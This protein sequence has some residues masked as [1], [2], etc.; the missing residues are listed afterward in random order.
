MKTRIIRLLF[1]MLLVLTLSGCDLFG[2]ISSISTD[3]P[4][5]T[6][7]TTTT[8][9]TTSNSDTGLSSSTTIVQGVT[10]TFIEN[11]GIE[12]NDI[13]FPYGTVIAQPQTTRVGYQLVGWY[14]DANLTLPFNF[15]NPITA[16][17][18]LYAKWSV[19]QVPVNLIFADGTTLALQVNYGTTVADIIASLDT[20]IMSYVGGIFSDLEFT[21]SISYSTVVTD[22]L[23]FYIQTPEF[24]TITYHQI[25]ELSIAEYYSDFVFTT[26]GHLYSYDLAGLSMFDNYYNYTGSQQQETVYYDLNY[27][28]ELNL[29]EVI[30]RVIDVNE[31]HVIVVTNQDRALLFGLNESNLLANAVMPNELYG[32]VDLTSVLSL[33]TGEQITSAV[34]T[35]QSILVSTSEER[36][37][38]W[39]DFAV[40]GVNYQYPTPFNVTNEFNLLEGETFKHDYVN[41]YADFGVY[42]LTNSRAFVLQSSFAPFIPGMVDDGAIFFDVSTLLETPE[43]I[44]FFYMEPHSGYFLVTES[45]RVRSYFNDTDYDL[46]YDLA[47]NETIVSFTE[48]GL[49]LTSF[50]NVYLL[51]NVDDIQ[52][53]PQDWLPEGEKAV[54]IYDS[55]EYFTVESNANK[56]YVMSGSELYDISSI[57][58]DYDLS[59]D[60]LTQCGRRTLLIKDGVYYEVYPRFLEKHNFFGFVPTTI[61][62]TDLSSVTA[63][64]IQNPGFILSDWQDME[65]FYVD[66][67]TLPP[68][69]YDL[70]PTRGEVIMFPIT[71]SFEN[72][73]ITI[74]VIKDSTLNAET[75][76][77]YIPYRY[78]LDYFTYNES[79]IGDSLVI[80]DA[81]EDQTIRVVLK[82]AET[83]TIQFIYVDQSEEILGT[84][85]NVV[86]SGDVATYYYNPEENID[87]NQYIEGY[88]LD[89]E[90]TMPYDI[91]ADVTSDL[92]IYIQVLDRIVYTISF[93]LNDTVILDY[94]IAQFDNLYLYW[95][96]VMEPVIEAAQLNDNE[97]IDSFYLNSE[98]TN[99]VNVIIG[100][101]NYTV[102]VKIGTI[103]DVTLMFYD[104]EGNYLEEVITPFKDTKRVEEQI[105][106]YLNQS[107]YGVELTSISETSDFATTVPYDRYFDG[108]VLTYHIKLTMLPLVTVHLHIRPYDAVTYTVYDIEIVS[109]CNIEE[110]FEVFK[111]NLF[112]DSNLYTDSGLTTSFNGGQILEDID[113]YAIGFVQKEITVTYVFQSGL[114]TYSSTEWTPTS[115][116]HYSIISYIE[117]QEGYQVITFNVFLD[118]NYETEFSGLLMDDITLYITYEINEPYTLTLVSP[119]GLFTDMSRS[120]EYPVYFNTQSLYYDF[121]DFIVSGYYHF[122]FNYYTNVEMTDL[123]IEKEISSDTT[124]YV[125]VIPDDFITVTVI[126]DTQTNLYQNFLLKTNTMFYDTPV[127]QY[128]QDILG[129]YENSNFRLY[130]DSDHTQPYYNNIEILTGTT[131]Y[132]EAVP[133]EMIT[134][135]FE[136]PGTDV[137][138]FDVSRYNGVPIDNSIVMG[139]LQSNGYFI[140]SLDV[141]LY[142]D[143]TMTL[144]INDVYINQN[145]FTVYVTIDY[146]EPELVTFTFIGYNLPD[147][148][149]EIYPY[150]GISDQFYQDIDNEMSG[151]SYYFEIFIDNELTKSYNQ[152]SSQRGSTLYV[153]LGYYSNIEHTITLTSPEFGSYEMIATEG[154]A[155][156][157]SWVIDYYYSMIDWPY[158]VTISGIYSDE[159]MT[160][161]VTYVSGNFDQT[162][163]VDAH[164]LQTF[165]LTLNL[166]GLGVYTMPIIEQDYLLRNTISYYLWNGC[167]LST[168]Y[169]FAYYTNP[170]M[171]EPY[172]DIDRISSDIMLY[173]NVMERI[174]SYVNYYLEDGTYLASAQYDMFTSLSFFRNIG[175]DIRGRFFGYYMGQ[176]STQPDF[177][178]SLDHE[179]LFDG[180]VTTY[181]VKIIEYEL[182]PVELNLIHPVTNVVETITIMVHSSYY[183]YEEIQRLDSIVLSSDIYLD[184]TLF[185]NF[186]DRIYEPVE[187]Y[188]QGYVRQE[189]TLTL[190]FKSGINS[191]IFTQF[192]D[193]SIP[194]ESLRSYI[195]NYD[196]GEITQLRF[197]TD[198]SYSIAFNGVIVSD[199]TLYVDYQLLE[200]YTLTLVSTDGLFADQSITLGYSQWLESFYIYDFFMSNFL[201]GFNASQFEF[202]YDVEMTSEF[203]AQEYN[204]SMTIY[205]KANLDAFF[206]VTVLFE[207]A[208]IQ[209]KVFIVADG[210]EFYGYYIEY[211]LSYNFGE[212]PNTI[213]RYYADA[214]H[215][216][217]YYFT[218]I[219][220][221]TT[222]Y[223]YAE[224]LPHSTIQFVFIDSVVPTFEVDY[225]GGCSLTKELLMGELAS[226]GWLYPEYEIHYYADAEL[227]EKI[228]Y[229]WINLDNKTIY[230]TLIAAEPITLT[231]HYSG[232][233]LDSR[234]YTVYSGS[235]L[236]IEVFLDIDQLIEE[237]WSLYLYTDPELTMSFYGDQYPESNEIYA[238][239]IIQKDINI[240]FVFPDISEQSTIYMF[241]EVTLEEVS[242]NVNGIYDSNWII[243]ISGVG[244]PN[245]YLD[246]ALTLPIDYSYLIDH[247]MT[248]YVTFNSSDFH[249]MTVQMT[250]D[251]TGTTYILVDDTSVSLSYLLS[252][253]ISNL[254]MNDVLVE[255]IFYVDEAMTQPFSE[256]TIVTDDITLYGSTII[257][258]RIFV[259]AF[260]LNPTYVSYHLSNWDEVTNIEIN[261]IDYL[262]I[263]CGLSYSEISDLV[264]YTDP[265]GINEYTSDTATESI[266]LYVDV[267]LVS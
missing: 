187:V 17:T 132:F 69:H 75:I 171:T 182:I 2:A 188:A 202:F 100:D 109:G 25:Q 67:E 56:L 263:C 244:I 5:L 57:M 160:T 143:E 87:T 86:E 28:M 176:V 128:A 63:V 114:P 140:P 68:G 33:Q 162:I 190:H 256:L 31:H 157:A 35:Y 186:G 3:L 193:E 203:V 183:V 146:I 138:D 26:D 169:S 42:Y 19:I 55:S 95:G 266:T 20:E 141:N 65:G 223:F 70:Y 232:I 199:M 76:Q 219:T 1:F 24:I 177:S 27:F 73:T 96:D 165:T 34:I 231:I 248:L 123:F 200:P 250:G 9:T 205:V 116:N 180:S 206:S 236:P 81:Y 90:F 144:R 201:I 204:T 79:P 39:G 45:G 158:D 4:P 152:Y 8:T 159:A 6:E 129:G 125:D 82:E 178:D 156:R 260:F 117:S 99:K 12:I 88:Y 265:D 74:T 110:I 254:L 267:I 131:L 78:D 84:I 179:M 97:F 124:V 106:S 22:S 49:L 213:Y 174:T 262:V 220:S 38:F 136:F 151:Y 71:L 155:L 247:S 253:K 29:N 16:S 216:Q 209:E 191:F 121:I 134:V 239:I 66:V 261:L 251:Y 181:Y 238:K 41:D 150:Y 255:G 127:Y 153:L 108:T 215:T 15:S 166:G 147:M 58:L 139:H 46:Q 173:V 107:Y 126:F 241:H 80:T 214:D 94:P 149:Y 164:H 14:T 120:Y 226:Y 105:L 212:I 192:S 189:V 77:Y 18:T 11:G 50:G 119:D 234:T 230:V 40:N 93:V 258:E 194:I 168:D 228:D 145:G 13:T 218:A 89:A 172:D 37:F 257:K 64:E 227:T 48:M 137:P 104:E 30:D 113:I 211:Y 72:Q 161:K 21:Q 43:N 217:P 245:F 130:L 170:E 7:T 249:I 240:T 221:D 252:L 118:E 185:I 53:V 243:H 175:Y 222:L 135:H 197:Y 259:D 229:E 154:D 112:I 208:P 60:D 85:T 264:F 148:I 62:Y 207:N 91:Y 237:N 210:Y 225:Y 233:D 54:A 224:P 32:T 103:Q 52:L 92:T 195:W 23:T 122:N 133:M 51:N 44:V 61:I 163:Y 59:T 184:P 196:Q 246:E 115:L 83:H 102:Y 98:F 198:S 142:L 111:G 36:V 10:L 167:N 47:P 235:N 101:D 242:K